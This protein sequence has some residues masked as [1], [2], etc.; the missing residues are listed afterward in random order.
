MVDQINNNNNFIIGTERHILH[1]RGP[2]YKYCYHLN[3]STSSYVL[4]K[5][6]H[7]CIRK[8]PSWY[9]F[10]ENYLIQNYLSESLFKL[11]LTAFP[12]MRHIRRKLVKILFDFVIALALGY[13]ADF[14]VYSCWRVP[15]S[16]QMVTFFLLLLSLRLHKFLC[17]TSVEFLVKRE[18]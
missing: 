18:I 3:T 12:A 11:V 14:L 2:H 7:S 9:L 5:W 13:I 8:K 1:K 17:K 6:L 10:I 4:K 15:G 16:K